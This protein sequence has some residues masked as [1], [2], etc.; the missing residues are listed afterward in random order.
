M[1]KNTFQ[2]IKNKLT[3]EELYDYAEIGYSYLQATKNRKTSLS[4]K[5]GN[6]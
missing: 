2:N 1:T 5:G 3:I 4:Y 6:Q